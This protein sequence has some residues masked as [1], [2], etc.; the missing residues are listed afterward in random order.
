MST[1]QKTVEKDYRESMEVRKACLEMFMRCRLA[2]DAAL[3]LEM[4]DTLVVEGGVWE[5]SLHHQNVY[6][7]YR[8]FV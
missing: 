5:R 6:V 8:E 3:H 2:D 1:G 4:V 7:Q